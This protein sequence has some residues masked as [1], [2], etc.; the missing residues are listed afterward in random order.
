MKRQRV[1]YSPEFKLRTVMESFTRNGS[2]KDFCES[3][4]IPT[5]TFYKWLEE[6]NKRKD[7]EKEAESASV[8]ATA[9]LRGAVSELDGSDQYFTIRYRAAT[10]TFHISQLAAVMEEFRR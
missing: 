8:D 6:Y 4:N 2:I 7:A 10:L 3:R 1:T 9:D 5:C